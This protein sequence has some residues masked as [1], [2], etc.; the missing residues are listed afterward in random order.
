[1]TYLPDGWKARKLKT[2][3]RNYSIAVYIFIVII[4][5]AL[6]IFFTNQTVAKSIDSEVIL[7]S[8]E[9]RQAW[10]T[11][12]DDLAQDP[13]GL[14]DVLCP[15]EESVEDII[16]EA[17]GVIREV[18]AY[19][20][21]VEETDDSP[22]IPAANFNF[23]EIGPETYGVDYYIASNAFPLY[24]KVNIQHLGSAIVVDRMNSRYDN[25]I[26]V[27]MG[28]DLERALNFG[29]QNLYVTQY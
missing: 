19:T 16:S 14:K 24:T 10:S 13:C 27:Y 22:C 7:D 18:S 23:C 26:D 5:G 11:M 8:L 3:N 20:S 6:V 17:T 9:S 28:Y 12:Y 1:M 29:V 25:R 4:F 15:T 2:K 21:R